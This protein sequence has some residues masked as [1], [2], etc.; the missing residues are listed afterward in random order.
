MVVVIHSLKYLLP[1]VSSILLLLIGSVAGAEGDLR[2]SRDRNIYFKHNGGQFSHYLELRGDGSYR[3]VV[4]GHLYLEERDRG[5]WQQNKVRKLLLRS[6]QHFRNIS[7]GDLLITMWQRDRLK[8][9]PDIRQRIQDFL[10]ANPA[11]EFP[12]EDIEH[13]SETGVSIDPQTK[14][15][16]IIV[17]G[18]KRVNRTDLEKLLVAIDMFLPSGEK[19]LFTLV[20]LEYKTAT[21]FVDDDRTQL[22]KAIITGELAGSS[23]PAQ[24]ADKYGY[25]EIDAAQFDKEMKE[26]RPALPRPEMSQHEKQPG[27]DSPE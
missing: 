22:T 24:A 5:K 16:D 21:I 8:T 19:N 20:P 9:L 1:T 18:S 3:R 13:I 6:D 4:R 15:S 26:A 23:T 25:K 2:V 17:L 7:S 12:A 10:K 14:S 27:Q 11:Q